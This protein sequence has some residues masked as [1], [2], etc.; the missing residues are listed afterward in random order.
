MRFNSD[1]AWSGVGSFLICGAVVFI[2]W[3]TFSMV[4]NLGYDA[5]QR[6][7]N[8]QTRECRP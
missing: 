3:L 8:G 1:A 7:A 6:C 5:G 2:A 4:F